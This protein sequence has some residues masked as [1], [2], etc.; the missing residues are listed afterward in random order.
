MPAPNSLHLTGKRGT[1]DPTLRGE[2]PPIRGAVPHGTSPTANPAG[3]PQG[4]LQ[5]S[6]TPTG[7]LVRAQGRT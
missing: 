6:I 3:D 1:H 2:A 7:A 5:V 4:I